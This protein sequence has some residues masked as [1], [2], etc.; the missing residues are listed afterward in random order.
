MVR[1]PFHEWSLPSP[2]GARAKCRGA[3]RT[4]ASRDRRLPK[5]ESAP[6]AEF[7]IPVK[8]NRPVTPAGRGELAHPKTRKAAVGLCWLTGWQ[9]SDKLRLDSFPRRRGVA[10]PVLLGP[11][12]AMNGGAKSRG[13]T[14]QVYSLDS[15]NYPIARAARWSLAQCPSG[16]STVTDLP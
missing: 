8:E 9:G 12:F 1:V 4:P 16:N 14:K 10:E 3:T 13:L 7:R 11:R 6:S 15:T 2:G 5:A